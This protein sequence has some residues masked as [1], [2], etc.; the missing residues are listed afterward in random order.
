MKSVDAEIQ[1][2]VIFTTSSDLV[3]G[4]YTDVTPRQFFNVQ[5]LRSL[6]NKSTQLLTNHLLNM[7]C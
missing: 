3:L 6:T 4:S 2:D 7:F 5:V 1:T